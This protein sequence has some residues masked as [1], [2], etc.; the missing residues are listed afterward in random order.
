MGQGM[1]R[2]LLGINP[3]PSAHLLE[4][5]TASSGEMLKGDT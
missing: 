2:R 4:G 3:E 5:F 1:C